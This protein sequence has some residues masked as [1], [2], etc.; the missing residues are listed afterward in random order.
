METDNGYAFMFSGLGVVGVFLNMAL[1]ISFVGLPS[2]SRRLYFLSFLYALGLV[3]YNLKESVLFGRN[4]FAIMV[5]LYI[6]SRFGI[7]KKKLTIAEA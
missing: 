6:V 1:L 2:M 7:E 3:V 4:F 5:I